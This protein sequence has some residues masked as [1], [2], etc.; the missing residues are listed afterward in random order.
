MKKVLLVVFLF[1]W[2]LLAGCSTTTGTSAV[3]T[4]TT[5]TTATTVP[6][7]T[8][9]TS[10]LG[11]TLG[12]TR[13][14]VDTVLGTGTYSHISADGLINYYSYS[15]GD[16]LAGYLVSDGTL[17]NITAWATGFTLETLTVGSSYTF[18]LSKL[19]TPS[20]TSS[21]AVANF[22]YWTDR[23]ITIWFY[24]STDLCYCIGIQVL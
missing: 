12:W 4:T 18:V 23:N 2:V 13:T 22:C 1:T 14:Q 21:S 17:L 8:K 16:K 6:V 20:T 7:V 15:G 3:T 19:G 11:V 9:H 10:F 24:K 5:S